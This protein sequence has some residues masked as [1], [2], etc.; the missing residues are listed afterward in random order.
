[1]AMDDTWEVQW[2]KIC[3]LWSDT[4]NPNQEEH[5]TWKGQLSQYDF[6]IIDKARKKYYEDNSRFRRPHLGPFKKVIHEVAREHPKEKGEVRAYYVGFV[7]EEAGT[8]RA[9]E[10]DEFVWMAHLNAQRQWVLPMQKRWLNARAAKVYLDKHCRKYEEEHGGR[11]SYM[12]VA[13]N[14]TIRARAAEIHRRPTDDEIP[15]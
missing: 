1:M 5:D 7:C 11:W 3:S 8:R 15:F 13:D 6:G 4:W 2:A 9:G 12:L 14:R 10:W